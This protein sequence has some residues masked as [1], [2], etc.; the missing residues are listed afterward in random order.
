MGARIQGDKNQV[1][2]NILASVQGGDIQKGV[3][4]N[5]FEYGKEML[6]AKT[7]ADIK[8]SVDEKLASSIIKL[9]ANSARLQQLSEIIESLPDVEVYIGDNK[10]GVLSICP[11]ASRKYCYDMIHLC[12]KMNPSI[13]PVGM[14]DTS[15]VK[16]AKTQQEADNCNEY[17]SLIEN[18][19]SICEDMIVLKAIKDN[20]VDNQTYQLSLTQVKALS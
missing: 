7:G 10:D 2:R 5:S 17:N 16:G 11:F 8:K 9:Q 1:C 20:A 13:T 14:V 18:C 12:D 6:F 3:I 15:D 19:V 4:S